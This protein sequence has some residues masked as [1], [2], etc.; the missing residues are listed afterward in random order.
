MAAGQ[1]SGSWTPGPLVTPEGV[2]LDL[3]PV[4]IGSRSIALLLDL[5]LLGAID[6]LLVLGLA[7]LPDVMAGSVGQVVAVLVVLFNL[8]GYHLLSELAMDGQTWGKRRQHLR[9]VA[10]DGGP[11]GRSAIVLRNLLRV[12]D[13]LPALYVVG[14]VAMIATS[15]S[16]R[17]GDL[18]AATIVVS[19]RR[20]AA[21]SVVATAAV[22][23]DWAEQVDVSR[24]DDRDYALA[25]G[26]LARRDAL[27]PGAADDLAAT[28]A[29]VLR[30]RV[31]GAP[32]HV[33]DADLVAVVVALVQRRSQGA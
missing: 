17:L 23:P 14:T 27:D 1:W 15:R 10:A 5:A 12:V 33:A 6:V 28:V 29:E 24:V 19:E 25:R 21:P 20:A 22:L 2:R 4:G 11:A 30:D 3:Q 9:V 31:V 18:T 13:F 26:W 8:F 16:Q 32:E 7:R